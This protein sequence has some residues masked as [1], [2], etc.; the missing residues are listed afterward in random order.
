MLILLG[1]QLIISS[2]PTS[3]REFCE[4]ASKPENF[5]K[6]LLESENRL[7]FL[8][9]NY[10]LFNEGICW[11]H[12][13]FERNATLLAIYQPTLPKPDLKQAKKIIDSLSNAEWVFKRHIVEIPGYN[14]LNE[15]SQDWEA[16]IIKRLER[17]QSYEIF[18]GFDW[19]TRGFGL[20]D[21]LSPEHLWKTMTILYREVKIR[22]R[23]TN[24]R[25]KLSGFSSHA[26]LIY[27]IEKGEDYFKVFYIDSNSTYPES[28]HVFYGDRQFSDY[29][30]APYIDRNFEYNL[31]LRAQKEFCKNS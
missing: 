16:E 24:L 6:L 23:L 31:A 8:N 15:F 20:D 22:G 19:L 4:L 25:L 27:D 11:W 30:G 28:T 1:L 21:Q 26:L 9:G 13:R 18:F 29:K 17:W 14:N 3:H 2:A 5:Q 12:S 7:A 10:G